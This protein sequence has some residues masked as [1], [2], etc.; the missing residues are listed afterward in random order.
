MSCILT[1]C[2]VSSW[3]CCAM[4]KERYIATGS[5]ETSGQ[6]STEFFYCAG[7]ISESWI[8][9]FAS[10]FNCNKLPKWWY[11]V[12]KTPKNQRNAVTSVIMPAGNWRIIHLESILV[13][14]PDTSWP[15][16]LSK[17]VGWKE[18]GS[19]DTPTSISKVL[20]TVQAS[21]VTSAGICRVTYLEF[22]QMYLQNLQN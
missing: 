1:F 14:C 8:F 15:L 13:F 18:I 22:E 7:N 6:I 3:R 20:L 5:Q 4:I 11:V 21:G 12:R 19:S 17:G 9:Y 10:D 2:T 16:P